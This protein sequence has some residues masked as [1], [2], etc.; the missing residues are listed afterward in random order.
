MAL[1][2]LDEAKAQLAIASSGSDTELQIYIDALTAAI[3]R[4]VGPITP[5]EASEVIEGRTATLCLSR[6]PVLSLT[7]VEPLL[8]GGQSLDVASLVLDGSAGIVR[9]YSGASFAGGLWRITYQAGRD[10]IPPTVQLA[11]RILLQHLWRTKYGAAR[12]TSG[13]GDDYDV[14]QP[15]PG[16]GYAIPNR[17]LELLEP[18][19]LPAAV[20]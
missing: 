3:E 18:Y 17:V 16:F 13:G 19:R 8:N 4:F 1:L 11:A 14:T 10:E 9:Q 15:T 6:T 12:G 20:A 2:T 5:Q 7:A